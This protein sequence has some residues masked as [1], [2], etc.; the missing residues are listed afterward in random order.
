MIPVELIIEGIYSYKERT[1]VD[2]QP[3]LAAQLFGIFGAVGSG[4]SSLLEAI[5]F[6]LYGQVERMTRR[7]S[8]AANMFNLD[9]D[10]AFIQFTFDSLVDGQRYRCVATG[11]RRKQ[12]PEL[13][14]EFYRL[15]DDTPLP[16][17]EAAVHEAIGLSYDHFTRTVIVPQG[18]PIP[19]LQYKKSS[20]TQSEF[21]VYSERQVRL[22]YVLRVTR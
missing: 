16:V 21:L 2:F 20:L 19:Q 4:K 11:K 15:T 12:G 13:S 7:D 14:R 22:R 8:L 17:E 10:Q 5:T 18:K 6:A 9:A 1:R 3:L